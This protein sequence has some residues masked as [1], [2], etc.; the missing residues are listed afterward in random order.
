MHLP[1][2]RAN[3]GN[4]QLDLTIDGSAGCQVDQ[5]VRMDEAS[6]DVLPEVMLKDESYRGSLC[7]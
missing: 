3:I 7:H 4:V 5:G 6:G 2:P 1:G